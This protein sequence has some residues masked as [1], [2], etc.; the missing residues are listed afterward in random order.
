MKT[1]QAII[2]LSGNYFFLDNFYWHQIE[3]QGLKG[4]STEHVYQAMK[5]TNKKDQINILS[6]MTPGGAKAIGNTI[7][8]RSDWNKV[9]FKIMKEILELKFKDEKLKQKLLDTGDALIVEGNSWHDNIWGVCT[10][11][12]CS[13]KGKNALGHLLMKIREEIRASKP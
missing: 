11:G 9:K 8:I 13:G 7:K 6:A 4:I 1:K 5:A 3:Y 12:D 2:S 10:C